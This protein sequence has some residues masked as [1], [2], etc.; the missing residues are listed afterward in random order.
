MTSY[1]QGLQQWSNPIAAWLSGRSQKIEET[2]VL[3]FVKKCRDDLVKH[4]ISRPLWEAL[5]IATTAL[6]VS[7]I[8]S[9][10]MQ[11]LRFLSMMSVL[12]APVSNCPA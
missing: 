8:S 6:E 7:E 1:E 5:H 12:L 9:L 2:Q 3:D 11:L 10:T 4:S